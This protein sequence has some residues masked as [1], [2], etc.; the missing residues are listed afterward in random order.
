MTERG[1]CWST[2]VNPTIANSH[3]IDGSG[4]GA[5][6]SNI[7][8]LTRGTLYHVRAYA[9]NSVGTAY[10]T[11]VSFTT[12]DIPTVLTIDVSAITTSTATSGGD[13]TSDGGT[14]VIIEGCMLE[15]VS[16]IQQ[17]TDH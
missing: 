3:T 13:I 11:D 1:V 2:T 6:I 16:R 17:L 7:S 12:W 4:T 14:P 9:T 15:H 8:G 10:G 5:F